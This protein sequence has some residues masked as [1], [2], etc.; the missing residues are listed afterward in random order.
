[1]R[2]HR[3]EITSNLID[4]NRFGVY[5]A[6]LKIGC[7]RR[8]SCSANPRYSN[9]SHPSRIQPSGWELDSTS[10]QRLTVLGRKACVRNLSSHAHDIQKTENGKVGCA[11]ALVRRIGRR[12]SLSFVVY[13]NRGGS[14]R[15]YITTAVWYPMYQ[16]FFP[17]DHRRD[18]RPE[19]SSLCYPHCEWDVL[20]SP[21][22]GRAC[23]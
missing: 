14:L 19:H 5:P 2:F 22:A 11:Y 3:F 21:Q 6:P 20:V 23:G 15:W 12:S 13:C 1:M 7:H 16:P 9:G 10:V 4:R 17:L 18:A 8:R